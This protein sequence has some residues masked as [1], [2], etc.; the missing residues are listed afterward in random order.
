MQMNSKLPL[1]QA[2]RSNVSTQRPAKSSRGL[3]GLR[4]VF[5]I[6]IAFAS[7]RSSAQPTAVSVSPTSGSG[8][9]QVFTAV[10]TDPN[11]GA[12][13]SEADLYVMSGVVPGSGPGWADNECI[14]RY[15]VATGT[16]GVVV[17]SG[18]NWGVSAAPGGVSSNSQCT[19]YGSGSS[20][21]VSGNTLTVNFNVVFNGA[22]F[23]GDKQ[24]YLSAGDSAGFSKNYQQQF[25]SWT[26]PALPPVPTAVSISPASG[27]GEE[28]T[29]S[30]TLTDANGAS[31][32]QSVDMYIMSNVVPG[33]A[34][35]WSAHECMVRMDPAA[36]NLYLV[37]DNGG[38]YLGPLALGA[39]AVLQNSQCTLSAFGSSKALSG[40]TL[41]ANFAVVFNTSNFFGGKQL[42]LNGQN[43]AGNYSSN[44][45]TQLAS[46]TVPQHSQ[47]A[48]SISVSPNPTT[49][50]SVDFYDETVLPPALISQNLGAA[51]TTADS[52][53]P[54]C[55][56]LAFAS[57]FVFP[58]QLSAV[59]G[60]TLVS[61][62]NF[63]TSYLWIDNGGSRLCLDPD[64]CYPFV[65]GGELDVAGINVTDGTLLNGRATIAL[66]VFATFIN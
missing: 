7:V 30:A 10:F 50:L 19:I 20:A 23:S 26:I 39:N 35:G 12:D 56:Q 5:S 46:F 1:S 62:P 38:S 11:N 15:Q 14:V 59:S 2:K 18:G 21:S 45:Q 28:Q 25:G 53:F 29:F 44:Y 60:P 63:E 9:V 34:S 36:N 52:P 27:S 58:L 17:D 32:V 3:R 40:N 48:C 64:A 61:G 55:P 8:A 24:I 37:A 65:V 47:Q 22:V 51:T 66:T 16:V 49:L 13:I 57:A 6:V 43:A 31:D 42:Y 33:S 41:T 54:I 4:I